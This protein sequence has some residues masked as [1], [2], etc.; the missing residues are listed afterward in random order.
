M[1][2][3]EIKMRSFTEECV[4]SSLLLESGKAVWEHRIYSHGLCLGAQGSLTEE[5]PFG[6]GL[7]GWVGV[8]FVMKEREEILVKE[9]AHRKN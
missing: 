5:G 7:E 4:W 2:L 1:G 8:F 9:I 6:L 3:T